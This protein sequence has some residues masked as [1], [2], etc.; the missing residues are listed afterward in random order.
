M[1]QNGDR[2]RRLHDA[3]G[4]GVALYGEAT[5]TFA[6]GGIAPA[7]VLY[8]ASAASVRDCLA[9]AH[10]LE[11]GVVAVG[12]GTQLGLGRPPRR[13]DAAL[14]LRSMRR[15]VA[16]E[17]ADMTVTVEAG[18]TLAELSSRL[19]M[20]GQWL[21][22]DPPCP[23]HTT[24]GA[25]IATDAWGPSRLSQGKVRDLLIGITVV[26]ADGRSVHGGGRVVKNV[27][28]YDLMKLFTGSLGTL[29][30]ITEATFKVRPRPEHSTVLLATATDSADATACARQVLAAQLAPL[31]VSAINETAARFLHLKTAAVCV[32]VGGSSEEVDVQHERLTALCA[33][34]T[35]ERRDG[36]AAASLHTGLR[37]LPSYSASLSAQLSLLPSEIGA[38]LALL[39]QRANDD[40]LQLSI[41]AQVGSGVAAVRIGTI[42]HPDYDW[43]ALAQWL[44]LRVSGAGGHVVFDL[45][46]PSCLQ[47]IDPWGDDVPGIALMRGIKQTL[48]PR[49][50]LSPGRF[51]GGI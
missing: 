27:A 4:D 31:Y 45:L 40:Q 21:P 30:V 18:C 37:D 5:R 19:T 10:E 42:D 1:A 8:P 13:Y 50:V 15:L 7:C 38:I 23:D 33:G 12:N 48:D 43:A 44:R 36:G 32:G 20:A 51:A 49:G 46:P 28:G 9:T 17:A 39:E 34:R 16:H 11:L 2:V 41:V 29:G 14:S 22:I 35:L 47:E 25:L 24:I 6:I 3:L 26:L